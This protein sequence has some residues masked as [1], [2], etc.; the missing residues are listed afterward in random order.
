VAKKSKKESA[1]GDKTPSFEEEL[2][3]LETIVRE[4][5]EGQLGLGDS[6]KR[7][8]AGVAHLKRCY[9]LLERAEQRVQLLLDVDADGGER[10]EAF[11]E[12]A[13]SLQEKAERRSR[14]RSRPS[15]GGADVDSGGELF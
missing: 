10:T 11:G 7:Y 12:Q 9:Q 1:T 15:G 5:E 4:L 6:L 14:R 8:E 2:G 3:C 13:M